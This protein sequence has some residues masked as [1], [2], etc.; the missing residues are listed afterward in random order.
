MSEEGQAK[1][2]DPLEK[3]IP[4]GPLLGSKDRIT[5]VMDIHYEHR[6]DKPV[7]V[8]GRNSLTTQNFDIEP[9]SRKLKLG[10]EWHTVSA[11][12]ITPDIGGFVCVEN[13]EG[14][15]LP[16]LPTQ[17]ER[18][19]IN[20][21]IIEVVIGTPGEKETLEVLP[22]WPFVFLPTDLS[23]VKLRA[24]HGQIRCRLVIYPR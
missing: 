11:D 3:A 19:D 21:R 24:R 18:E 7:T 10:Q 15:N 17:E 22:G 8:S 2:L 9:Y 16:N 13:L 12:W 14:K 5:S 1:K 23:K 4:M 6:G 20:K